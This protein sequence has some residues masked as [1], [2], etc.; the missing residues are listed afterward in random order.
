MDIKSFFS[1]F[2]NKIKK[3]YLAYLLKKYSDKT[4]YN[5]F[6]TDYNKRAI[7]FY[8]PVSF[9]LNKNHEWYMRDTLYERNRIIASSL[10]KN[11]FIVDIAEWTNSNFKAK[12]KYDL[13]VDHGNLHQKIYVEQIRKPKIISIL[14][15]AYFKFNNKQEAERIKYFNKKNKITAY[16][17]RQ[18]SEVKLNLSNLILLHGNNLTKNTYPK[19]YHDKIFN[20]PNYPF[21]FLI[22]NKKFEKENKQSFLFV[23]SSLGQIHKGL[24][25]LLEVFLELQEFN[26]YIL[27]KIEKENELLSIYSKRIA[28]SK[29]IFLEGWITPNSSTFKNLI[30]KCGFVIHPSCSEGMSGGV[31]NC[32]ASGLIPV[33][34]KYSGIDVQDCGFIVENEIENI[35]KQIIEISKLKLETLIVKS[36]LSTTKVI[37]LKN[38]FIN[39]IDNAI[40][41]QT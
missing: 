16:P 27:G 30:T 12:F 33:I 15:T 23:G 29:N 4:V 39:E 14:A 31:I 13:I 25:L 21:P 35:K 2:L 26:L 17:K 1:W 40:L 24:D 19:I 37:G 5:L 41:S 36:N 7:L 11:K 8:S 20:I 22:N 9:L 18:I 6:K 28:E 34:S 3:K 10:N 38:K 32:M